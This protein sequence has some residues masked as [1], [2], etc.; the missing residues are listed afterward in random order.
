MHSTA[1]SLLAAGSLLAS[2]APAARALGISP[3]P[4][5]VPPG[6]IVE[7]SASIELVAALSGIPSGGPETASTSTPK[8]AART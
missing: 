4:F 7:S 8:P 6:P 2:L 5:V 3:N 1:R